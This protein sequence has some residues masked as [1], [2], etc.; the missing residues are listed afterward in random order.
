L[1]K[2][3]ACFSL[4]LGILPSA[5]AFNDI[6]PE[7]VLAYPADNGSMDWAAAATEA[8]PC[9]SA[10]TSADW[11]PDD[12]YL[13]I[14]TLLRTAQNEP[15]KSCLLTWSELEGA[16]ASDSRLGIMKAFFDIYLP[17]ATSPAD[18]LTPAIVAIEQAAVNG[19][20]LDW[21]LGTLVQ[22]AS[23]R[24][25]DELDGELSARSL[26][27]ANELIGTRRDAAV[28]SWQAS[29]AVQHIV[30][31]A[32]QLDFDASPDVFKAFQILGVALEKWQTGC[33]VTKSC[34]VL[35]DFYYRTI[36][37]SALTSAELRAMDLPATGDHQ[38][39][40]PYLPNFHPDF[41]SQC[42][43]NFETERFSSGRYNWPKTAS[44]YGV[45]LRVKVN[46][47][48]KASFVSVEDS[49][50]SWVSEPEHSRRFK[51]F[52]NDGEFELNDLEA[53]EACK[54]GGEFLYP[55]SWRLVYERRGG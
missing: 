3:F 23:M 46:R 14:I 43:F 10:E 18:A 1:L 37:L 48:G 29:L 26:V 13:A 45:L 27:A 19:A 42:E 35:K 49:I 6:K 9:Q 41:E 40:L 44:A 33:D 36:T 34:D 55:M 51:S 47:R 7:T 53:N 15:A 22:I 20:Q 17:D 32:S 5:L 4:F 12:R 21:T 54:E 30:L 28:I 16:G 11:S 39:Y 38:I 25:S 8:L 24:T 52:I 50:P 31:R 2:T